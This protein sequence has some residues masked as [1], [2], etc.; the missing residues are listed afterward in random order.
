M[1]AIAWLALASDQGEEKATGIVARELPKLTSEQVKSV[2]A[3]K[4]QL[5]RKP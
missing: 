1:Q 2:D 5:I 3:L 4:R